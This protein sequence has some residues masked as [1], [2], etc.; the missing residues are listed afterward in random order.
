MLGRRPEFLLS[1][2]LTQIGMD[3]KKKQKANIARDKGL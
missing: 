1:L 3:K 2:Q